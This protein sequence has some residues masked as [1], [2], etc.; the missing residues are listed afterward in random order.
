MFTFNSQ[1]DYTNAAARILPADPDNCERTDPTRI[2]ATWLETRYRTRLDRENS[3]DDDARRE[4][5]KVVNPRFLLRQWVLEEV[6]KSAKNK[7]G[8]G[9]ENKEMLDHVLRMALEPFNENWGGNREEEERLCGDVPKFHA[10]LQC[11]CSS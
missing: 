2:M 8:F 6:V 7:K 4:R 5:M 3:T 11:S 9:V 10:G 1:D